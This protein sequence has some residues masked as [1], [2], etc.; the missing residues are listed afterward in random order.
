MVP[1]EACS[2][3]VGLKAAINSSTVP[4]TSILASKR[5]PVEV[6]LLILSIPLTPSALVTPILWTLLTK[7][8][9]SA[10]RYSL[11]VSEPSVNSI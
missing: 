7:P 8:K 4:E 3:E 11:L 10:A 1:K 2:N 6:T 9:I 5:S